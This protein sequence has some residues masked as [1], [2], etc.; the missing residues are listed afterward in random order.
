MKLNCIQTAAKIS[1]FINAY[2]R[3][4]GPGRRIW[5]KR[6][7]FWPS[8]LKFCF[9]DRFFFIIKKAG[10]KRSPCMNGIFLFLSWRP[11]KRYTWWCCALF[12]QHKCIINDG[13]SFE[14][15]SNPGY[16]N[17]FSIFK[18]PCSAF[19]WLSLL[20]LI[21]WFYPYKSPNKVCLSFIVC[22]LISDVITNYCLLF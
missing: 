18:L 9:A 22:I 17:C 20:Y 10:M 4:T 15:G 14:L 21:K 13:C 8:P 1:I 12:W 6:R 2:W 19:L 5:L 7:V 11:W 16:R 3:K